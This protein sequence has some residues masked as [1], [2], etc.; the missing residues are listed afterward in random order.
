MN[1]FPVIMAA[2]ACVFVAGCDSKRAPE[3]PVRPVLSVIITNH[4]N[5]DEDF[6]GTVEPRYRTSLS[7]RV[8]GR[9]IVRD[10][11]AG[12]HVTRG[13][14][15]A[16]LDPVALDLAV[17]AAHADLENAKAQLTNAVAIEKRR[18]TLLEQNNTST[19][20]FEAAQQA[21]E[22]AD[23]A[24][25]RAQSS[26]DKAVEQRSYAELRAEFDGI[27]TSVEI[28]VGQTVSPGQSAI[29]IARP[30]VREAVIDVPDAVAATLRTGSRFQVALQI[31]PARRVSGQVREI[32]PQID[33][34]TNSRRV[35]IAL[36]NPPDDFRLGTTITAYLSATTRQQIKIP[37][38]ALL[39]RDGKAFVWA[40]DP[41]SWT[42]SLREVR[43]TGRDDAIATVAEGLELGT[44]VV[45][46]GVHSLSDGQLV[47]I[48]EEVQQ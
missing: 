2:L 5:V 41:R 34:L 22:A 7:F 23:A 6:A 48:P 20:Q 15:L 46:A 42:V 47:K 27:V 32:A 8:L 45:T 19:D 29:T 37:V 11:N 9:V 43:V 24:V 18:R 1:P 14:R 28:E 44:R 26:L 3:A 31:A 33:A 10:V 35:K 25:T 36:D 12:D 13:A 39:E 17:T 38:T 21:R 40:V 4:A 30:E 16:A